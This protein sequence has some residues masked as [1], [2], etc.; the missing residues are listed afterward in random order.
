[1]I[2]MAQNWE[3][4]MPL[5]EPKASVVPINPTF[6]AWL[7]GIGYEQFA[8]SFADAG[9]SDKSQLIGANNSILFELTGIPKPKLRVI[10]LRAKN[11]A[12]PQGIPP[13]S[14]AAAAL[15]PRRNQPSNAAAALPA[16]LRNPFAG[17]PLPVNPS[18]GRGFNRSN[19]HP[20]PVQPRLPTH[21]ILSSNQQSQVMLSNLNRVQSEQR[22]QGHNGK[23]IL[24]KSSL[25]QFINR[26]DI[27]VLTL[28]N[29]GKY[30][31]DLIKH[32][33]NTNKWTYINED[34]T[35]FLSS[36]NATGTQIIDTWASN[37][38]NELANKRYPG[39][40]TGPFKEQFQG[41]RRKKHTRRH[42]KRT[43]R[44]QTKKRSMHRSKRN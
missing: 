33:L 27:F 28:N 29:N 7:T 3:P 21:G 43:A 26:I 17:Q 37:N 31:H 18:Q 23:Y 4:G 44:K 30:E 19:F 32:D 24:R 40:I 42:K 15:A 22:L 10:L 20:F 41:G 35:L 9:I 5:V 11:A 1:M 39:R 16:A 12:A 13:S 36:T 8:Q 38:I 6:Q 2:E 34:G 25:P 14:A